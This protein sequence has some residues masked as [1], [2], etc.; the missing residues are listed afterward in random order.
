METNQ[1]QLKFVIGFVKDLEKECKE[2]KESYFDG[3]LQII[4]TLV[5]DLVRMNECNE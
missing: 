3:S 2:S 5:E 1:N 4:R